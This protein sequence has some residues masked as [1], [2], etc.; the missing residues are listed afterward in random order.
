MPVAVVPW[1]VGG[2][3]EAGAE[4]YA[5]YRL[6]RLAQAAAQLARAARLAK[7]LTDAATADPCPECP[8]ERT[9]VISRSASPQAAQHIVDAQAMGHP[10]VLTLDRPGADT[11]RAASL[12][13]IPTVPLMDRDEYPPATFAEGGAGASV[14]S[15]PRSDNRSAGGQLGAQI[16]GAKDGCKITMIAGP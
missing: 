15:I 5:A 3:I 7:T 14:R 2:V 6:Y 9:V 11:R 10:S 13:G 16:A 1:V 12:R 4:A 8:C